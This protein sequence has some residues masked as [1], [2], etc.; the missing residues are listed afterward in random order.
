MSV[1]WSIEW[2]PKSVGSQ[3]RATRRFPARPPPVSPI[4]HR[5]RL[6]LTPLLDPLAL[7]PLRFNFLPPLQYL[8]DFSALFYFHPTSLSDTECYRVPLLYRG[9]LHFRKEMEPKTKMEKRG[10]WN[11]ASRCALT[12][13]TAGWRARARAEG[14]WW[15]RGR[16]AAALRIFGGGVGWRLA[17]P[18]AF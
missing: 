18:G 9:G 7:S 12:Q 11:G 1:W 8:M 13:R 17:R 10:G 16:P 4:L 15:V 6:L 14:T 5:P 2:L 3:Q